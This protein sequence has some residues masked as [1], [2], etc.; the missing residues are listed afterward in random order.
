MKTKKSK[1]MEDR[2]VQL[3]SK[4]PR[5]PFR[6]DIAV[7]SDAGVP[8]QLP[9]TDAG[10]AMARDRLDK[11]CMVMETPWHYDQMGIIRRGKAPANGC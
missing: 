3:L 1:K 5:L 11:Y 10:Q 6:K 4:W 9:S 2:M 8:H 7:P